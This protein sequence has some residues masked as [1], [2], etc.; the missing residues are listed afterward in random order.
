M[1][2]QQ[3]N[4]NWIDFKE[5]KARVSME[6]VLERYGV[7]EKLK[8]S[9]ASMVGCCPIHNGTNPRQFSV[10][11]EKN[12][13]NCFGNCQTGGNVLDFVAAMEKTDLKEAATLLDSWFPGSGQRVGSADRKEKEP[14]EGKTTAGKEEKEGKGP[15]SAGRSKAKGKKKEEDAADG[16]VNPPLKFELKSLVPDH[17]FFEERGITRSTI[18]HFGLGFC[19]SE[20]GM[21]AGRI[22]IPVHNEKGELVAYAG[23]AVTKEQLEEAKYKQPPNFLK[24]HVVYNLHRLQP[25]PGLI[26]VESFLSV[27]HLHQQ[28]FA[29]TVS[30]MGASLSKEQADLIF[31]FLGPRGRV[32]FMLDADEAGVLGAENALQLLGHRL[33]V[34]AVDIAPYGKK[35]HMLDIDV[36]KKII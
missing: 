11:F 12:A 7:L 27:Y 32:I 18:E 30:L 4:N 31:N 6:M 34:K 1:G 15:K 23:R 24:S 3:R 19:D 28:G 14:A 8:P 17:P 29:F 16:P 36:L 20:R 21:M 13:W 26:V 5:I 2:K 35:P 33:F 25:G 10:S 22:V 9:G